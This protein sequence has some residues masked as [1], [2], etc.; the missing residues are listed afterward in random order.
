MPSSGTKTALSQTLT[1]LEACELLGKSKRTVDNYVSDGRLPMHYVAGPNG[2]ESRFA[3]ADVERVKRDNAPPIPRAVPVRSID[4]LDKLV[5]EADQL[6]REIAPRALVPVRSDVDPF[7]GLAAHLAKLAAAFPTPAPVLGTWL[8][9]DEAATRS[10]LPKSWLVAQ[11]K[12]GA[13]FAMNVGSEKRAAW[14]FRV[15][16]L[17]K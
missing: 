10:G 7:A 3:L 15:D 17:A 16:A 13:A 9:L 5:A 11:A 4:P 6:R 2:R 8:S 12:A 14:R 1:K